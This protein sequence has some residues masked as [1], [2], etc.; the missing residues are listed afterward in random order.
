MRKIFT[1]KTITKIIIFLFVSLS[2]AHA[3]DEYKSLFTKDIYDQ[4]DVPIGQ[5][6]SIRKIAEL[7]KRKKDR[8]EENLL[9]DLKAERDRSITNKNKL[10]GELTLCGLAALAACECGLFLPA[11]FL[12]YKAY[13]KNC[14]QQELCQQRI[15]TLGDKLDSLL[16]DLSTG[17]THEHERDYVVARENLPA[18]IREKIEGLLLLA[19]EVSPDQQRF[20]FI[21]D[22]IYFP[23]KKN[24][25]VPPGDAQ[26]FVRKIQAK[27][28]ELADRLRPLG[29]QDRQINLC[30]QVLVKL[31]KGSYTRDLTRV[32]YLRSD[33][34]HVPIPALDHVAKV[35]DRSTHEIDAHDTPDLS[36]EVCEGTYGDKPGL[37]LLGFLGAEHGSRRIDPVLFIENIDLW[38]NDRSKIPRLLKLFDKEVKTFYS[39]YFD[40]E[41]DHS[42]MTIIGTG[43]S[44]LSTFDQAINSRLC[45][46]RW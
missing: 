40:C 14:Q 39:N 29:Y 27:K 23:M 12:F 30:Q 46:Y 7:V 42:D 35:L 17:D 21:K 25:L 43:K 22:L 24:I 38:I 1:Q 34:P 4:R 16:R 45:S 44:E 37:Y 28:T 19:Y 15:T 36:D 31:A 8:L 9:V 10:E 2:Q 32:F 20:I 11:A 41:F 3:H 5:N 18:N 26:E 13:N 6:T 33:D